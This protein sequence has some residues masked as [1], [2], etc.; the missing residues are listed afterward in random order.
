MYTHDVCFPVHFTQMY[1]DLNYN[2]MSTDPEARSVEY[3][4][5][6]GRICYVSPSC[7]EEFDISVVGAVKVQT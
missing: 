2:V 7:L 3:Q 5:Y 4:R 1:S 6:P